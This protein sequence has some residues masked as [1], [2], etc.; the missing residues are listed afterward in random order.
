MQVR[1][2]N[3][4]SPA[5]R[6]KIASF[7]RTISIYENHHNRPLLTAVVIAKRTHIQGDG[8]F[9]LGDQLGFGDWK[10]LKK[11]LDIV[12]L[13]KCFEFWSNTDNY[14]NFEYLNMS[15]LTT[16]VKSIQDIMRQDAGVDGDA[17][18]ISQLAWMIFLKIFDDKEKEYELSD[19]NYDLQIPK[20]SDGETGLLMK[21]EFAAMAS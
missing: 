7:F 15:N 8:F 16:L 19:D 12:Q 11:V 9:K 1:F 20:N 14:N 3:M 18:R 17:Q 4:S 5:D 2:Q 6:A 21:R 10:I 13:N